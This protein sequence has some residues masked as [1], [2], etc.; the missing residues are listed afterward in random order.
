[1]GNETTEEDHKFTLHQKLKHIEK[2]YHKVTCSLA[3]EDSR[4]LFVAIRNKI[5][6]WVRNGEH[7]FEMQAELQE[8]EGD[9]TDLAYDTENGRLF[10]SDNE[11]FVTVWSKQ[12]NEITE[13]MKTIMDSIIKKEGTIKDIEGLE[14]ADEDPKGNRNS[15]F[16]FSSNGKTK[17]HKSAI[18]KMDINSRRGMLLTCSKDHTIRIGDSSKDDLTERQILNGH[19]APVL[20][21]RYMEGADIVVSSSA[22][23]T[24]KIWRYSE[25]SERNFEERK[26][27]HHNDKSDDQ[28][29]SIDEMKGKSPEEIEISS[30]QDLGG[31]GETEA[32]INKKRGTQGVKGAPKP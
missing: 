21:V 30:K 15:N 24:L 12:S 13:T 17:I 1:M 26:E 22:D 4:Y 6:V 8:H 2:G 9:I 3:S 10:S 7:K 14:V 29:E 25:P 28:T 31:A 27:K 23:K 32:L 19:T 5:E 18:Y 16:S 20:N 11:G